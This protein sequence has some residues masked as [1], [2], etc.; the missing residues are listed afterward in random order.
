MERT[1]SIA[2]HVPYFT[3]GYD[4]IQG[5]LANV[6]YRISDSTVANILKQHGIEPAPQRGKTESW[7]TFLRSH[8]ETIG[9]IDFTT[10][11][12]WTRGGLVTFYVLVAMRLKSREIV[13]AG[14]T[15]SPDAAWVRQMARNLTSDED[16]F[17]AGTTHLILDR[18]TKFVPL[19]RYLEEH[20]AVK[21][22]LLPPRSPDLNAHLERQFRSMKSECLDRLI[23]FR[24]RSLRRALR[25]WVA[26]YHAER[27]H[28]G[29][30]NQLITPQDQGE[31]SAGEVQRIERLGGLLRYYHRRAA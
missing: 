23:F 22:M 14:V 28:Q 19:R 17:L 27:N 25:Q 1:T 24:E 31:S 2:D 15:A 21:P 6:G 29:L 20:T 13:V 3:W 10:V 12:V 5:A 7:A 8:W 30:G 18:D 9:A 11:E 26:H 4:R 16:G